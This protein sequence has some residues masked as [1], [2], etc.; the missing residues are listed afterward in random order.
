MSTNVIYM[1]EWLDRHQRTSK[2]ATDQ[3][4]LNFANTLYISFDEEFDL[5]VDAKS[6]YKDLALSLALY[7]ED[8]VAE[9]GEWNQFIHWHFRLY[10]KYLPFYQLTEEYM[11]DEINKEDISLLV[12]MSFSQV[13]ENEIADPFDSSLL[14]LSQLA[15]EML[16]DCFE[17]APISEN[18]SRHWLH[19][20][21]F[22]EK[23]STAVELVTSQ[24]ASSTNVKRFLMASN[25]APLMYFDSYSVLRHFFVES[26]GWDDQDD[27]FMLA[28]GDAQNFVLYGNAKGLLIGTDV[29]C[30]FA[31]SG[32]SCYDAE[33]AKKY[34]YM[35]FTCEG[36]CPFDLL[37]YAYSKGLLPD[38]ELPFEN[39][40]T[41]LRENWDFIARWFLGEYYEGD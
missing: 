8:C 9:G 20:Y 33:E 10:S 15:Y 28:L 4:Y 2:V 17:E 6:Q 3:W 16:D 23:E 5:E 14:E 35:M 34:G 24:E 1:K 31:D 41:L 37:K 13:A 11:L 30:F 12:W 19:D 25:D 7:L 27:E 29:A 40:K 22:M 26:L 36:L 38:V 39:G 21:P 18:L 32:N